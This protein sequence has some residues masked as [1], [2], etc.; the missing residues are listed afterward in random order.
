MSPT[1]RTP[2]YHT[3]IIGAGF[4]GIGAAINLDKAGLPDYLVFEAGD[5]VGEIGRA[6]V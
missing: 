1:G 2:D 6:H 3:L 5:G 4:S